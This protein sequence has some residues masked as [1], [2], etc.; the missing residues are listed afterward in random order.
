MQI[1]I[2]VALDWACGGD[3]TAT[4]PVKDQNDL[5]VSYYL[6]ERDGS[7]EMIQASE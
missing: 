7:T 3:S 2:S 5:A 4:N 6:S 1:L